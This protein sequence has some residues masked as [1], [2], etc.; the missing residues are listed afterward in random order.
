MSLS[1]TTLN[2]YIQTPYTAWYI[3][4]SG[5]GSIVMMFEHNGFGFLMVFLHYAPINSVHSNYITAFLT[6]KPVWISNNMFSKVWDEIIYPLPNFKGITVEVW[7]WINTF[8]PH[9]IMDV[10]TYLSFIKPV[11]TQLVVTISRV[12]AQF[13]RH[14]WDFSC[15]LSCLYQM[16]LIFKEKLVLTH[17]TV[18]PLCIMIDIV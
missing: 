9:F 10:I 4:L 15:I 18:N 11:T 16:T 12:C 1:G 8:I 5:R 13:S 14:S 7:E 17:W 6:L 3:E 2:D